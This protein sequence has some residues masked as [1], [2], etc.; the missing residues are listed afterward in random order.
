MILSLGNN[1]YCHSIA[2]I[3]AAIIGIIVIVMLP[4]LVEFDWGFMETS[5]SYEGERDPASELLLSAARVTMLTLGTILLFQQA[6]NILRFI[7]PNSRMTSSKNLTV[8]LRG[9]VVRSEFGLKQAAIFKVLK[10]NQ[11]A[12]ALHETDSNSNSE[13]KEIKE[14]EAKETPSVKKKDESKKSSV[15]KKETSAE[16]K[17]KS[18]AKKEEGKK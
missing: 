9:S 11:Y 6:L 14:S 8:L 4:A 5:Y 16:E 18:S 1:I 2:E 15:E 12:L 3:I 17:V 13:N 10:M 7:I